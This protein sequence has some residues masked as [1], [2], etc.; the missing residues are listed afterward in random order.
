MSWRCAGAITRYQEGSERISARHVEIFCRLVAIS[1]PT[2]DQD[3]IKSPSA[4]LPVGKGQL[5]RVG[6]LVMRT[7][8]STA[9][10][11]RHLRWQAAFTIK[12]YQTLSPVVWHHAFVSDTHMTNWC[13]GS[14]LF[15][16]WVSDGSPDGKAEKAN[17]PGVTLRRSFRHLPV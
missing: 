3:V 4:S 17:I 11:P 16:T 6:G 8:I 5:T 12:A 7:A 15:L 10:P 13:G 1:P 2:L 9:A 14:D